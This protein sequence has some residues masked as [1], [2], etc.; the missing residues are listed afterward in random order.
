M[1]RTMM[2]KNVVNSLSARKRFGFLMISPAFIILFLLSVYPT[3]YLVVVSL[4]RWSIIPTIPRVF[5]GLSQ[6]IHIFTSPDFYYSLF[7]TLVFTL[8][9]VLVEMVL[10]FLLAYILLN[11]KLKWLRI[12]FLLSTVISPIVIGLVWR[13]NLGYDLG[14]I[15]YFL[16]SLGS[17]SVNWLGTPKMAVVSI[18]IVDIWQWT[19]F[20]MLIYLAGLESLPLEPFEAAVVDGASSFQVLTHIVLPQLKSIIAVILMFRTLDAFKMFDV[21]YM[22]TMGGPGNATEVLSYKIWHTAFF[23]NKLGTGAALS[24]IMIIIANIMMQS[25]N[26]IMKKSQTV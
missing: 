16:N 24:I 17:K 5:V 19:P 21:V 22:M 11:T 15:N 26:R 6:Y 25:F 1:L 3:I 9:V 4:H 10:G 18:I 14:L 23:E 8:S 12:V 13:F 2:Q 20:A 7:V